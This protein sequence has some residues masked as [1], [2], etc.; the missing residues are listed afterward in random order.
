MIQGDRF[1]VDEQQEE[2]G[3]LQW[4]FCLC[5]HSLRASHRDETAVHGLRRLGNGREMV[6]DL[7]LGL[8]VFR[9]RVTHMLTVYTV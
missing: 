3:P 5:V 4:K 1:G 2:V 7:Y 8:L 9:P 6:A